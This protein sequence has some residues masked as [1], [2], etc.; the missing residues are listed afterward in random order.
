MASFIDIKKNLPIIF[1]ALKWHF[2]Y[3]IL[4]KGFPLIGTFQ[5]T[6]ICNFKCKMCNIW[7]NPRKNT[8]T[9]DSFRK[10]IDD[11]SEMG[12][13]YVG[14]SGGEPL[15]I[16]NIE[17]YILYAKQK[18]P[19]VNLVTNGFLLNKGMALKLKKTNLDT[20][21]ISIDALKE[22]QD[23]IRR[24]EGSFDKSL[25]AIHNIKNYASNIQVI[26]NTVIS[27]WNIDDL[28]QLI[29]LVE[30][31]KV[32]QKFQPLNQHPLYDNQK[33]ENV[34]WQV[35]P[36][37]IDKL[38]VI[39]E[40]LKRKRNVLNSN[41]FLSCIPDYFQKKN[42]KGLFDEDC[43]LGHY[44]CDIRENNE[45]YPC[46]NGLYAQGG[47]SIKKG[48]KKTYKSKEYKELQKKLSKCRYCQKDFQICH[49][50]PRVIFPIRNFLK[51]KLIN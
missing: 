23:K 43:K 30:N 27:P 48:L 34:K 21:S 10:Y 36:D 51:Y 29:K 40:E 11:L 46:L 38:K 25:D 45:I 4:K 16:K 5:L 17:K 2:S 12:C 24:A 22:K 39:I 35:T 33:V 50:E 13:C 15:M 9:F 1:K 42:L 18:I 14:L 26:V 28:P 32:N 37:F 6:N 49:I 44:Y 41:Y 31:F 20:I 19:I 7:Q 8:M 3:Y 47:L